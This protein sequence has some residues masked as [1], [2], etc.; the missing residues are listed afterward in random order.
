MQ[1]ACHCVTLSTLS[2]L[3]LLMP[4]GIVVI[5][6]VVVIVVIIM[7]AVAPGADTGAMVLVLVSHRCGWHLVCLVVLVNASG[8]HCQSW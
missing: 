8:G 2:T 3:S 4:V 5:V 6:S 1:M 7:V